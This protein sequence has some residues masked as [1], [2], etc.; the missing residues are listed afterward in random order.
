VAVR[1]KT[2]WGSSLDDFLKE[3]RIY[4]EAKTQLAKEMIAW[5]IERRP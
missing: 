4:E 2:H 3:E 1:K 5:Q